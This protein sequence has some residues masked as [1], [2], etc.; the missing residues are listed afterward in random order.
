MAQAVA[1]GIVQLAGDSESP[2]RPLG[3]R[4][5]AWKLLSRNRLLPPENPQAIACE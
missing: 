5:I 3:L 4:T 2:L 1:D